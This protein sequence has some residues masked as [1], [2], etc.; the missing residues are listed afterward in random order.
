MV[1]AEFMRLQ[2]EFAAHLRD[3]A[4]HAAPGEHESRRLDIYRHAVYF[5]VE[6]FLRDNYPRVHRI[7]AEQA[8]SG[9]VRD[10][11]N[12]HTA[13]ANAFVD[14]PREFLHYLEHTRNGAGD[15]PFLLELAHFDWLE[16][17]V[18][19]DERR[20]DL[21]GV[22]PEGDLLSGVPCANPILVLVTYRFP[23]HVIDA[24][25]QPLTPP[26]RETRIAAFR[27]PHNRY[28]FLDLNPAAARLLERVIEGRG[29]CGSALIAAVGAELDLDDS[30]ALL[31]AG[32]TI[33]A[34]M[35]ERGAVLG[36][37]R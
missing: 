13:R 2:R 30:P 20:V 37:L 12:R 19:A 1:E 24:E 29:L 9:L 17:L 10:Y 16:T 15:A 21:A 5:N 23:V 31:T 33:L 14:V 22:D 7:M 4:T 3:P 18:G 28:G 26:A 32:G 36:T 11:L 6:R 8:W 35:R 27:D 25:F 34:R